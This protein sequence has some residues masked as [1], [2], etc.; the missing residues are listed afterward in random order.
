MPGA[1]C[2]YLTIQQINK[3]VP[4]KKIETNTLHHLLFRQLISC[5]S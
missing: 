1:I 2:L 4:F 5:F 3:T